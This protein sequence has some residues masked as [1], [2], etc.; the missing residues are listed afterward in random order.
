VARIL[1]ADDSDG[2]R[3]MLGYALRR[4]GHEVGEAANG[5]SALELL[6]R[7]HFDLVMLDVMMPVLDGLT[8]CRMLRATPVLQ[9]LPILV[10]SAQTCESEARA[11]GADAFFS[12][13]YRLATVRAAV[14]M[15]VSDA[16]RDTHVAHER[17]T[18]A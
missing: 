3:Q 4:D 8:L 17:S 10:L 12:K 6:T 18:S 1:I 9:G 5:A 13:P 14:K 7:E 11:A 2:L 16:R 15:L